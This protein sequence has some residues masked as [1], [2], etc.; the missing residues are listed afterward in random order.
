MAPASAI[1]DLRNMTFSS[2]STVPD[3]DLIEF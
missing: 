3:R 1:I 2:Y